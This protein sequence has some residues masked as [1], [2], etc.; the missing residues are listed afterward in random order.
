MHSRSHNPFLISYRVGYSTALKLDVMSHFENKVMVQPTRRMKS[1][2][3][4]DLII[5]SK[6]NS[7]SN[8]FSQVS[9]Y[10]YLDRIRFYNMI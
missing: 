10:I 4:F 9:L 7:S 6:K 8:S 3:I 1:G 5:F 2:A